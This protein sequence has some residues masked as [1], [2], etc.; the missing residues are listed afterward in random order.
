MFKIVDPTLKCQ[1]QF[2]MAL[3]SDKGT[4]FY[5]QEDSGKINGKDGVTWQ[6]QGKSKVLSD[7]FEDFAGKGHEWTVSMKIGWKFEPTGSSGG[8]SILGDV[9]E[10]AKTAGTVLSVVSA[11]LAFF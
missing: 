2:V 3:K 8:G 9:S 6:K 4:W 7:N 1:F 10:V 5:F 11:A